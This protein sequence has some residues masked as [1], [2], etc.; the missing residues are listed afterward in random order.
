MKSPPLVVRIT[1]RSPQSIKGGKWIISG[2]GPTTF[3]GKHTER[4][5]APAN[6]LEDLTTRYHQ[7]MDPF[8]SLPFSERRSIMPSCIMVLHRCRGQPRLS[9]LLLALS[10]SL[11][12]VSALP[13]PSQKAVVTRTFILGSS[14]PLSRSTEAISTDDHPDRA[15]LKD[16]R[17]DASNL[18]G[19][20][21]IPAALFAGASTGASFAMPLAASEG[22]RLGLVKRVYALLM[23][24]ALSS[25]IVAV[26]VSTLTVGS[27]S[28][29]ATPKTYSVNELIRQHY[30]L[31]WASTRFHFF[32]GVLYF[33]VGIGLRA[34]VSI[35]CPVIAKAAVGIISSCTLLCV[36]FI[37]E[38]ETKKGP[39]ASCMD[40][41][42]QLPLRYCAALFRRARTRPLFTAALV[43][44]LT[45]WG[46]TLANIPHVI[47]FLNKAL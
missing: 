30:E 6:A 13:C 34:W 43:M 25:A 42:L 17:G 41:V 33:I 20:V 36:A 26:V 15:E 7:V 8:V 21:R 38:A 35:A 47:H 10:L 3:V 27:L 23:M 40:G 12:C 28:T 4:I 18:F 2:V 39:S 31:E 1:K 29:H 22:L 19:N 37:Q 9:F 16:F 44:S 46:Y 5:C 14:S 32:S 45:T 11:Y 24:A